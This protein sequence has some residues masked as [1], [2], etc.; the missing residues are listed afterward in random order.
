MEQVEVT[1]DQDNDCYNLALNSKIKLSVKSLKLCIQA[2]EK[3]S[4]DRVTVYVDLMNNEFYRTGEVG[5][6]K[7]QIYL[8]L[9]E[10]NTS[11]QHKAEIRL[12]LLCLLQDNISYIFIRVKK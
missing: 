4:E 12:C 5:A 8:D 11:A 2:F 9:S 10:D 7:N 3:T 1:L 6:Y